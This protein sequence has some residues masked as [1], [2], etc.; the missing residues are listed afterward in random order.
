M[1]FLPTIISLSAA[2]KDIKKTTCI[3]RSIFCDHFSRHIH[4]FIHTYKNI[5]S[6]PTELQLHASGRALS[7]KARAGRKADSSSEKFKEK[8][9]FGRCAEQF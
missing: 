9:G 4:S 8:H 5:A 2:E 7:R 1:C 6:K 3:D